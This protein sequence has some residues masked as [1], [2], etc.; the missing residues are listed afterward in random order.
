MKTVKLNVNKFDGLAI[1]VDVKGGVEEYAMSFLHI[2]NNVREN[3]K[4]FRVENYHNNDVTVY[5]EEESKES[6]IKYLKNFG[7]IKSIEKMLMYQIEDTDE[8]PS[9]E[10]EGEVIVPYFGY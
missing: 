1:T 6:L 7:E 2:F 3:E 10:Y 9:N 5:C 8:F 4:L